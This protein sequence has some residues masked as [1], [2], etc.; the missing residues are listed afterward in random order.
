MEEKER[1]KER[2][3][4]K[5]KREREEES[6][7][8]E[9][10][11]VHTPS[12]PP[13]SCPP[14]ARTH[15]T[16]GGDTHTH[17]HGRRWGDDVVVIVIVVVVVVVFIVVDDDDGDVVI[18][19]VDDDGDD[20]KKRYGDY[21]SVVPCWLRRCAVFSVIPCCDSEDGDVFSDSEDFC[22]NVI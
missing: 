7:G 12:R 6:A 15:S 2:E 3:R 1:K 5:K 4:E 16:H 10:P 8:G 13:A 18:V 19:V 22:E 14:T 21:A 17:T 11:C 9:A 20:E